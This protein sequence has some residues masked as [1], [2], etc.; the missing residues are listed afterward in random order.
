MTIFTIQHPLPPKEA[1][2]EVPSQKV[3]RGKGRM[4]LAH[5]PEK[6]A[7]LQL[8]KELRCAED[9]NVVVLNVVGKTGSI[10]FTELFCF[11]L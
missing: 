7:G 8:E 1:V 5:Q 10:I 4:A 6:I 9:H 3:R 11:Q 2:P